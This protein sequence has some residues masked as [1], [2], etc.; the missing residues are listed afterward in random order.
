[1]H[2]RS[3]PASDYEIGHMH[4]YIGRWRITWTERWDQDY[5][6]TTDTAEPAEPGYL[7]FTEDNLGSFVAGD[8]RGWFEFETPDKGGRRLFIHDG[9]ESALTIEREIEE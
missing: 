7:E 1:M 2:Q 9:D 8:L 5:A 3:T 4:D 6:D